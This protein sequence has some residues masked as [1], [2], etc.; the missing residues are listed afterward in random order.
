MDTEKTPIGAGE[1]SPAPDGS[2]FECRSCKA[3]GVPYVH[4]IEEMAVNDGDGTALCSACADED[5]VTIPQC[6][7]A[8]QTT[9]LE[10]G[11]HDRPMHVCTLDDRHGGEHVCACGV[12]WSNRPA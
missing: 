4:P 11:W 8:R 7:A 2:T 5:V 6:N 9:W 12:K 3:N 1:S 10:K